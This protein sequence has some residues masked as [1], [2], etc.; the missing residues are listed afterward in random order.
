MG[1]YRDE[2][3]QLMMDEQELLTRID[4]LQRLDR[5]LDTAECHTII[6]IQ[7]INQRLT[8]LTMELQK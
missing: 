6:T 1:S 4:E 3:R 8:E 5:Q 2:D 7:M